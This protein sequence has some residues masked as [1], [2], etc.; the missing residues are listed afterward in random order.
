MKYFKVKMES[1]KLK[2]L[3]FLLTCVVCVYIGTK[4]GSGEV[5]NENKYEKAL[6]TYYRDVGEWFILKTKSQV[7]LERYV[8]KK[9][10]LTNVY[11]RCH[12]I[13]ALL[14]SI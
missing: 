14:G 13:I 11:Y 4:L 12:H 5:K 6:N 8:N 1:E 9:V 7:T 3:I 2:Y 10:I